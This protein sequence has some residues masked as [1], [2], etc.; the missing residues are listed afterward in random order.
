MMVSFEAFRLA[1][2]W[3][4]GRATDGGEAFDSPSMMAFDPEIRKTNSSAQRIDE[5]RMSLR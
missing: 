4:P 1:G 3:R 5:D 2:S